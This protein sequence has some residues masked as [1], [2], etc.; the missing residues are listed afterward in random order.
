MSPNDNYNHYPDGVQIHVAPPLS[1]VAV[2]RLTKK[3]G[4]DY[5]PIMTA[6]AVL[7]YEDDRFFED[8]EWKALVRVGDVDEAIK[9]EIIDKHEPVEYISVSNYQI[10]AVATP[11]SIIKRLKVDL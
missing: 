2:R 4:K 3:R 5:F 7:W 6:T 1:P 8:A 11:D 10:T 9:W